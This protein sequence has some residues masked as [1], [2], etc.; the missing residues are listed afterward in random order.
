M[1]L[2]QIVTF[3]YLTL[4]LQKIL[5]S[6]LTSELLIDVKMLPA[7]MLENKLKNTTHP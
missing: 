6:T 5:Q 2:E 1:E 4:S 3:D 7:D